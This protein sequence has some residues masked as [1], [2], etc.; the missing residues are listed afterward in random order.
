MYERYWGLN[1]SP[2]Q[3]RNDLRWFVETPAHEEALA[4]LSFLVEQRRRFGLLKGSA[5]TGK[6]LILKAVQHDCKRLGDE[7]VEVNLFGLDQ[8]ELLWQLVV[9]LRL[10][11]KDNA[12]RWWLWQAVCDHLHSM[13]MGR[14]GTVFLFDHLDQADPECWSLIE[15]VLHVEGVQNSLTI[16]AASRDT[17]DLTQIPDLNQHSDLRIE[18]P[19][20]SRHETATFVGELL[21]KAGCRRSIFSTAALD[22]LFRLCHGEAR[23]IVRLCDLALAAAAHQ[24]LDLI[25]VRCLRSA[26]GELP[27][28]P[29]PHTSFTNVLAEVSRSVAESQLFNNRDHFIG[30]DV[31]LGFGGETAQT[32][33]QARAA[34]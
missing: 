16:L 33:P 14:R 23:A 26:S 27:V 28:V 8:H 24:E 20:L 19:L 29:R 9:G 21:G 6:T 18:L 22:E 11:P 12:T 3:A 30:S 1:G 13:Q 17:F 34:E 31:D 4:R 10:S 25:D 7:V 15:R 2:F 5:G 32:K